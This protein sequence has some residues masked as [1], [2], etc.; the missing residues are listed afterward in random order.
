[1]KLINLSYSLMVVTPE[2]TLMA[3]ES[4]GFLNFNPNSWEPPLEFQGHIHR[5]RAAVCPIIKEA[6]YQLLSSCLWILQ[7]RKSGAMTWWNLLSCTQSS[8]GGIRRNINCNYAIS[9]CFHC[10]QDVKARPLHFKTACTLLH[11]HHSK[12]YVAGEPKYP[13]QFLHTY[14]SPHQPKLQQIITSFHQTWV[15]QVTS[16]NFK[17]CWNPCKVQEGNNG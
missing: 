17:A 9:P 14:I 5:E 16:G 8:K 12:S 3:L 2:R 7:S 11:I 10:L 13:S 6:T 4:L 15:L 1:M